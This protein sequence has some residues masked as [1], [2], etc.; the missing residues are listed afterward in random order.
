MLVFPTVVIALGGITNG[1]FNPANSVSMISMMPKEHRGFATSVNHVVFGTG[2]VLGIALGGV[3][4]TYSFESHAGASGVAP[5]TENTAAFVAA[6]NATLLAGLAV[7][8]IGI[9][10]SA[11]RRRKTT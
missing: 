10:T 2:N 5:T 1:L 6:L 3:L 4:M 11:M 8:G 7:S 9:F